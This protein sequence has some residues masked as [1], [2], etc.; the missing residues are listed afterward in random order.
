MP[1]LFHRYATPLITGL[2]LV[3]LISGIALFFHVGQSSFHEMHEWLSMVLIL[4]FVLHIW[5]NWR[6]F[7]GYF[8]RAPM[9]AALVVS[10]AAALYYAIPSPSAEG[11]RAGGPPQFAFTSA[12]LKNPASQVAPLLGSSA[13]DLDKRLVEAGFTAASPELPLSEI[14]ARSGK[15]EGELLQSVMQQTKGR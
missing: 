8:R 3:S 11:R 13:Q 5:K 4:P 14:A 9:A 2:F 15:S 12:V 7:V 1:A 10:L 6:S